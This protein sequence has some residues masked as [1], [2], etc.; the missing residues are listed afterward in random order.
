MSKKKI[1]VSCNRQTTNDKNHKESSVGVV[2]QFFT[3]RKKQYHYITFES[4][5]NILAQIIS[6]N[7]RLEKRDPNSPDFEKHNK[8][9]TDSINSWKVV[10]PTTGEENPFK[11]FEDILGCFRE[12]GVYERYKAEHEENIAHWQ[13]FLDRLNKDE[14]FVITNEDSEDLDVPD[15]GTDT[16]FITYDV[17]E[18]GIAWY[19]KTQIGFT[20]ELK[21]QWQ[22][23]S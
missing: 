10:D 18:K 7:E 23:H 21:F 1:H 3:G 2:I 6:M 12:P 19:M 11:Q 8:E 15:I 5:S 20:A 16:E 22:R 9:L 17:I 13:S 4:R 14:S